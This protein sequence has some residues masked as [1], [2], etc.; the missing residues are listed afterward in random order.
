MTLLTLFGED[1]GKKEQ[2]QMKKRNIAIIVETLQGAFYRKIGT[3]FLL[4]LT[5]DADSTLLLIH[6]RILKKNYFETRKT[7]QLK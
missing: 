1:D 5:T 3:F 2:E 6:K 4:Q 7:Y